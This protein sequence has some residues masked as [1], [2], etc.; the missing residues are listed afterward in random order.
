LLSSFLKDCC[1]THPKNVSDLIKIAQRSQL[2]LSPHPIR[3]AERSTE[4]TP[5]SHGEA[6]SREERE[7]RGE[8]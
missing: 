6:L 1:T 4:L 3:S 5:K 8:G 2:I 7:E